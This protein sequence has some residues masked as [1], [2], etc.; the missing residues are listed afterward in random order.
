[1]KSIHEFGDYTAEHIAFARNMR[2]LSRNDDYFGQ[3]DKT[4]GER[5]TSVINCNSP[6]PQQRRAALEDRV[7][8]A[9]CFPRLQP[10]MRSLLVALHSLQ[11]YA[12]TLPMP[13]NQ[14][15]GWAVRADLLHP[16]NVI[17]VLS[18]ALDD[19][20]ALHHLDTANPFFADL[21]EQL[22]EMARWT[23]TSLNPSTEDRAKIRLGQITIEQ[24]ES[25][26]RAVLAVVCRSFHD[27]A[28]LY[29]TFPA[30]EP[31]PKMK[32]EPLPWDRKE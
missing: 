8:V 15:G 26:L 14:S 22:L 3:L 32:L 19:S 21:R 12:N 18:A 29:A 24:L 13:P 10:A 2:H 28:E 6:T 1:M 23:R 31:M 7:N 30:P 25:E 9:D 17:K 11:A 16:D 27:F 4:M 5:W 20:K